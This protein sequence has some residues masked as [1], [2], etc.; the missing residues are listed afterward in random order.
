MRADIRIRP[1]S[2]ELFN[3]RHFRVSNSQAQPLGVALRDSASLCHHDG[4]LAPGF[5]CSLHASAQQSCLQ[6]ASA[7]SGERASAAQCEHFVLRNYQ[8]RTAS[9]RRAVDHGNEGESIL[10]L[11][12]GLDQS[13]ERFGRTVW[14]ECTLYDGPGDVSLC[15]KR[16][17]N[18]TMPGSRR[19]FFVHFELA[20]Q[21]VIQ[22]R[23]CIPA[24]FEHL[25]NFR[26][27]QWREIHLRGSM[28]LAV[29]L[30]NAVEILA[31]QR[32]IEPCAGR[33]SDR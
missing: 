7:K 5:Q 26:T 17:P 2:T 16:P 24:F 11:I 20:I 32:T 15:R 29:E 23:D 22:F 13:P 27:V 19:K 8:P 25:E 30:L 9:D 33:S 6:A 4:V 14:K 21:H 10:H 3:R 18:F 1:E 31:G 28:A 12:K